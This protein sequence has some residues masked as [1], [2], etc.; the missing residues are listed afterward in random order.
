MNRELRAQ[1]IKERLEL[2]KKWL[3]DLLLK[4]ELMV[5]D[6]ENTFYAISKVLEENDDGQK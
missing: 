1:K 6:I 3:T 5:V 4:D 2:E